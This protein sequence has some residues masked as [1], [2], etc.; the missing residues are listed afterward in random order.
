MKKNLTL[1]LYILKY[2]GFGWLVYRIW[3]YLKIKSGILQYQTKPG[4]W[5]QYSLENILSRPRNVN[6][7]NYKEH[8][9]KNFPGFFFTQTDK[10]SYRSYLL[11]WDDAGL[12]NSVKDLKSGYFRLFSHL[13]LHTGFP[14]DWHKNYT[15]T[16]RYPQNA[17]WSTIGDFD[18]GDIKV[19]WELSRFGFVYD[20]V[21]AYWI[22]NDEKYPDLFWKLV[23]D[24]RANNLPNNGVN[25]KCGQETTFRVMAW[26]WGLYGFF[27]S[28]Y[29]T[30]E[31]V[32][33]LKKMIYF[34]GIRIERNI[35]YA[36]SQKNNHGISEAVG[37]WTIGVLFPEFKNAKRCRQKGKRLIEKLTL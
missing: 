37:L 2:L 6:T 9:L 21:R 32:D 28:S 5:E 10:D 30:P 35:G 27:D 29:S 26:C 34:S 8:R 24:W 4:S 33:K 16:N 18:G 17:H 3:Y 15:S 1:L 31:R 19:V 36:L 23:E 7:E 14:P 12:F 22:T 20:L 13:K 11:R 25:W